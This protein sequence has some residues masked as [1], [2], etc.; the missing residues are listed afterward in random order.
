[1]IIM[2][3]NL[4]FIGLS[5]LENLEKDIIVALQQ[6][7]RHKWAIILHSLIGDLILIII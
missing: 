6:T 4:S 5:Q 1:M 3:Y 2:A 7:Q